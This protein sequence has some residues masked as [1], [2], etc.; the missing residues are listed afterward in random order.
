MSGQ[1]PTSSFIR[2]LARASAA[3]IESMHRKHASEAGASITSLLDHVTNRPQCQVKYTEKNRVTKYTTDP[4]SQS[5]HRSS[6]LFSPSSDV[7]NLLFH[8]WILLAL[9]LLKLQPRLCFPVRH[10]YLPH[11]ENVLSCSS[12]TAIASDTAS[13]LR[14]MPLV[15]FCLMWFTW[16]HTVA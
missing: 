13:Q 12:G 11:M 16:H 4:P 10:P 3:C 5:W 1:R 6:V 14:E 15:P 8:G 7:G 9:S 2:T